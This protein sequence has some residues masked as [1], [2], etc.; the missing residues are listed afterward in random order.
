MPDVD[1][2]QNVRTRLESRFGLA[3]DGLDESQIRSALKQAISEV[4][5]PGLTPSDEFLVR[6]IDHLP[7]S[8]SSLFRHPPLWVWL[9][10]HVLTGLVDAAFVRGRPVELVSVGCSS[11]Q[12]PFSLAI[13]AL[14]IFRQKGI[15]PDLAKRHL[16]VVGLDSS[17]SRLAI[18]RSGSLNSWSVQRGQ[19]EWARGWV[20][21]DVQHSGHYKV[22][23]PVRDVCRFEH[24][25]LMH[26]GTLERERL[27]HADLVLCQNVLVYFKHDVALAALHA[28]ADVMPE[29]SWLVVAPVEA[30][31]QLGHRRLVP[32][33]FVGAARVV[34]ASATTAR[35]RPTPFGTSASKSGKKLPPAR[36]ATSSGLQKTVPVA[37]TPSRTVNM[38]EMFERL[39]KSAMENA[40]EQ[41][42]QDARAAVFLS[43]NHPLARLVLGK[44]LMKVDLPAGRRLLRELMSTLGPLAQEDEVPLSN[45][46][47][48]GQVADAARLLLGEG[49]GES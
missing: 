35:P 10:E 16:E 22:A 3:L 26:L 8:E 41:G 42:L 19:P 40:G 7:I 39:L 31:L 43:P 27:E 45:G 1:V 49:G 21:P 2:L 44:Q 12:E 6:L 38:H 32:S 14:E 20:H 30:H 24:C 47:S 13:R 5:A 17:L 15:A 28:I 37:E 48:V 18:A 4:G 9:T 11:G 34:N 33:S 36:R 23:G 29:G 25:N 46:L